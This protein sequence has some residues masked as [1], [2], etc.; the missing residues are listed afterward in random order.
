MN[1]PIEHTLARIEAIGQLATSTPPCDHCTPTLRAIFERGQTLPRAFDVMHEAD[2][3]THVEFELM[4]AAE[5]GEQ[6]ILDMIR[7]NLK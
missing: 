5:A 7:K 4:P 3:V 1:E 6:D 2:C